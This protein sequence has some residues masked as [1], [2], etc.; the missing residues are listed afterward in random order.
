[1]RC[2]ACSRRTEIRVIRE[3]MVHGCPEGHGIFVRQEELMQLVIA[4]SQ[5]LPVPLPPA[6]PPQ[7]PC[8]FCGHTLEERTV[9]PV[10]IWQCE[11]CGV[12]WLERHR[13]G[14]LLSLVRHS[15]SFPMKRS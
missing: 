2:P 7:Y 11:K 10:R 14:E 15:L 5:T 8:P 9:G 12:V 3:V 13:W 6:P 1:M 4:E